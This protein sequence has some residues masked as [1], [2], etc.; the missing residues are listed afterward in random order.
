MKN[1]NPNQKD[2]SQ[3]LDKDLDAVPDKDEQAIKEI[4]LIES[5]EALDDQKTVPTQLTKVNKKS[6]YKLKKV[7]IPAIIIILLG[8]IFLVPFTR[9][10]I[11]GLFLKEKYSIS[12]ID[13]RS[14]QP[15]IGAQILIDNKKYVTDT[16]GKATILA[17]VGNQSLSISKQYYAG[18]SGKILIPVS[19][20][21]RLTINLIAT[22]RQ[23]EVKVANKIGSSPLS[24]ILVSADGSSEKTNALG[25]ADIVLPASKQVVNGKLTG[26]GYNSQNIS[27]NINSSSN[28]YSLVP[29]GS[30]YYLSNTSGN[31]DVVKA[32]LDGSNQSTV[33]AGNGS[34][35]IYNTFL[36]PSNDWS[37]L[38][39]VANRNNTKP[40][41]S[42]IQTSDNSSYIIDS[43]NGIYNIIGWDSNNNLIYTVSNNNLP[44]GSPGQYVL[45]SYNS[46]TNQTKVLYQSSSQNNGIS[47]I[48]EIFDSVNLL[49]NGSLI[50][51]TSWTGNVSGFSNLQMN[52]VSINDNGTGQKNLKSFNQSNYVSLINAH[53]YAPKNLIFW[54]YPNTGNLAEYYQYSD[55]QFA[56]ISSSSSIVANIYSQPNSFP[57]NQSGNNV[58]YSNIVNGH[59]AI[60]SSTS[61]GN[62]PKQLAL[63]ENTYVPYGWYTDKY[64]IINNNNNEFYIMPSTGIKSQSDLIK[65]CN[66]L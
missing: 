56:Q 39:L 14:Y 35:G 25:I 4:E 43:T 9:Y 48:G 44:I 19:Q 21:N 37:Y 5:D 3:P 30:I 26:A 55:Y 29:A 20:K 31:V 18:Y 36:Y 7:Y 17:H 40:C 60:F 27:I 58:I 32:N 46:N 16:S 52:I 49:P 66:H 11:L 2:N 61:S 33:L 53:F 22:G 45:K 34:E 41:L 38:A 63:L 1:D 15:V 64:I 59:N 42:I 12:V 54:V 6:W 28:N 10:K 47:T 23:V 62:N 65:I 50:Y 51:T 13:S 57:T 24:G 8:I